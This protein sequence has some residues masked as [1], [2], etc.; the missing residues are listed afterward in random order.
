M[1]ETVIEAARRVAR[2]ISPDLRERLGA[3]DGPGW[4][5]AVNARRAANGFPPGRGLNDHRFCLAVLGYDRVTEGW[6][7]E[8]W[9]KFTRELN[10]LA[11]KAHHDEALTQENIRRAI[12]IA[13]AFSRQYGQPAASSGRVGEV[14]QLSDPVARQ[15]NIGDLELAERAA[16]QRA[17]LY[18]ADPVPLQDL[19]EIYEAASRWEDMLAAARRWQR[20]DPRDWRPA[21]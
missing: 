8:H 10:G 9:R 13:E 18:P 14:G 21:A 11:N 1:E 17:N 7:A 15:V 20:L 3:V 5:E 2:L 12:T 6:A 4:L 19:C 16:R